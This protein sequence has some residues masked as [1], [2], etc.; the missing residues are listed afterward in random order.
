MRIVSG[1]FKGRVFNPPS[2]LP[3]RPTTDRAKESLFNILNNYVDFSTIE[4]LDL[5]SGTGNIS[6]EFLSRGVSR[7][8]LVERDPKCIAFTKDTMNNLGVTDFNMVQ[9]DVFKFIGD[10]GDKFDLI[11]ADPPY[12]LER[13]QELPEI[14]LGNGLVKKDG[15]LIVEH[16]SDISFEKEE[17]FYQKRNSGEV[18]FSIFKG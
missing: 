8:T 11:F 18:N 4:V 12:S 17:Q 14:I 6:Y 7:I 2:N 13:I 3:V 15:I 10:C 5:F 9:S 16:G 1:E